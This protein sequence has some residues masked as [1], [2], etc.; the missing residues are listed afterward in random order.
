MPRLTIKD[1]GLLKILTKYYNYRALRQKGSH[2]FLTDGQH[3]TTIPYHNRELGQGI[4]NKILSD[5]NLTKEDILK[6]V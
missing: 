4:L 2:I 6:Y 5:C 3:Y 1:T